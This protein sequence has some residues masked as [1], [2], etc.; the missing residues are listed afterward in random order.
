MQPIERFK[1]T[2]TEG[3][4]WIYILTLAKDR[5]VTQD[6][7]ASGIFEKFGFL[8]N[9]MMVS[10]VLMRLKRQGMVT[11]ERNAGKKAY[12]TT[13]RGREELRRAREFFCQLLIEKI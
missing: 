2:A 4:L 6:S 10:L 12:K 7:V 5:E 13:E 3:N 11:N 1:K 9:T 8:P